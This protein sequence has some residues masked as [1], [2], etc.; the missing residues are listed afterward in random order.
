MYNV[1]VGRNNQKLKYSDF[2]QAPERFLD[3]SMSPNCKHIVTVSCFPI[4]SLPILKLVLES[5]KYKEVY[6]CTIHM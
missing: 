1:E 5:L 2:L 3:I 6:K 4:P